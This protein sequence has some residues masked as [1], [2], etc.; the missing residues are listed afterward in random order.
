MFGRV[1]CLWVLDMLGLVEGIREWGSEEGMEVFL[2]V[3]VCDEGL[4]S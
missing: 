1:L 3:V 4:C 2:S